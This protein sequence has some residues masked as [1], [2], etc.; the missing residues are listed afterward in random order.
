MQ[1][2]SAQTYRLMQAHHLG[3]PLA[4]YPASVGRSN[5][6]Y[7]LIGAGLLGGL[8]VQGIRSHQ[9]L[10]LP[11][12]LLTVVLLWGLLE[13]TFWVRNLRMVVCSEGLLRVWN[14]EAESIRWDEL[15]ELWRD[16]HGR[17]TFARADGT[18]FVI[19]HVFRRADELGASIEEEVT[20]QLLP[21]VEA[22]FQRGESVPFGE[23][24][25]NQTGLSIGTATLPWTSIEGIKEHGDNLLITE[26]ETRHTWASVALRATPN[27]CVLEALTQT[28]R[29]RYEGDAST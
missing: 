28:M 23:V 26:R 1:Q 27:V 25:V 15:R 9:W 29:T 6:I 10:V 3:V 16:R 13:S 7:L 2:F 14:D 5:L 8:V 12:I 21:Q 18:R 11:A 24:Q 20:R 17:Y 22:A 19:N 4:V